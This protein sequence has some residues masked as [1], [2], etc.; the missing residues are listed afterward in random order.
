MAR[1]ASLAVAVTRITGVRGTTWG[2]AEEVDAQCYREGDEVRAPTE[3]AADLCVP[4]ITEANNELIFYAV[5]GAVLG[6]GIIVALLAFVIYR[7]K[8]KA[9]SD[10]G[11]FVPAAVEV[12][13]STEKA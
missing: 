3:V 2:R 4:I 9:A 10:Q 5:I 6:A 8:K 7:K 13:S 11:G 12:T 1:G